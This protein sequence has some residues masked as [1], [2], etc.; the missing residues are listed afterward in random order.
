MESPSSLLIVEDERI[1]S[2]CLARHFSGRGL[3]VAVAGS[4][5]EAREWLGRRCFDAFL[6]DV[7]LPDGDG[8]SLLD[9][10]SV[11]RSVVITANPDPE[12]LADLGVRFLVPKPIDLDHVARVVSDLDVAVGEGL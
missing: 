3:D 7:G 1:L 2:G 8:L 6:L 4:L 12:R 5:A 9:E 11:D 10:V